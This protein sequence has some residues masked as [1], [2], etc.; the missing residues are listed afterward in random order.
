MD[1]DVLEDPIRD[2]PGPNTSVLVAH[3]WALVVRGLAAILFGV[4]TLVAPGLTL[5]A[6]VLLWGAYALVDGLFALTLAA[7]ATRAG[8]SWGWLLFAGVVSVL[9]GVVTFL[10]PGLTAMGLLFVIAL[11]AVFTGI[12]QVAAAVRLRSLMRHEWLLTVSGVLSIAFG[13][14][15]YILPSTGALALAWMIGVYAILFGALLVGLGLKF[16][17][18]HGRDDGRHPTG[19]V[20][21]PV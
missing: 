3:W 10:W 1:M 20:P 4:L 8:R 14:L 15:L 18:S 19:G 21:T 11:W 6:L 13:L 12:A 17:P 9:A 5:F 7:R 2:D 16:H